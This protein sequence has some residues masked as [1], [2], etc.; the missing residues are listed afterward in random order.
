MKFHT[1]QSEH[2][3]LIIQIKDDKGNLLCEYD[4]ESKDTE[5]TGIEAI[6]LCE[7]INEIIDSIVN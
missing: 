6:K 4:T 1:V 2:N 7:E 5:K 3:T